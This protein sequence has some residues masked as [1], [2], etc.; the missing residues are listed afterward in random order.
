[1]TVNPTPKKSAE[2]KPEEVKVE[3]VVESESKVEDFLNEKD[4]GL[5]F[6]DPEDLEDEVIDEKVYVVS[7]GDNIR[8][9]ASAHNVT[10][11]KLTDANPDVDLRHLIPGQRINL[12]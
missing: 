8:A 1:M 7:A 5:D 4:D 9:I 6:G 2:T 10:N 3:E 11:A 12:P